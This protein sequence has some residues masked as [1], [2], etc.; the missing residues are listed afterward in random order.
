MRTT[1]AIEGFILEG[2]AGL[3]APS[4]VILHRLY[5]GR[6][7]NFL[8]D[9][10]LKAIT[11]AD[12]NR[13]MVYLHEEYKPQRI[14][15]PDK[16]PL[17]PAAIDNHWKS[18]R[19]FFRWCEKHLGTVRPDLDLP[20]P[21]YRFPH[22]E[23]LTYDEVKRMLNACEFTRDVRPGNRHSYRMKRHT[24]D[25]D[26]A[27]IMIFLDTG[28]RLG[29]LC[30]L[31]AGDVNLDNG[32]IYIRPFGSGQ[33]T[34]SRTVR[35]GTNTR[36]AI[37]KYAAMAQASRH[38]DDPLFDLKLPSSVRGVIKRISGNA[39]VANVYPHRFRH[40]FAIEYLRNGGDV[41]T[42]KELLGHSTLDM[43]QRYLALSRSDTKD[44]HRRASPVDRWKL[45]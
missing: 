12:L 14:N 22:V 31:K 27:I 10:Q 5:L 2:K 19:G 8:G 4:T 43:V 38:V 11:P 13:F 18:I 30:R 24:A 36:R 33:K 6:L 29:E 39:G 16:S 23:P 40:T 25:R 26:K 37:W 34:K 21:K 35:I 28:I 17:S 9:P 1:Q 7:A 20:R 15:S 41:F 32:E 44:A 42:L 45:E 3:Y